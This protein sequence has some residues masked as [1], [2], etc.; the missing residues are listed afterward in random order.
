MLMS[1]VAVQTSAKEVQ[2]VET[3]INDD[4][5]LITQQNLPLF[6]QDKTNLITQNNRYLFTQDNSNLL[7]QDKSLR[8]EFLRL[9]LQKFI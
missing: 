1:A 7:A 2:L 8:Q 4:G 3:D 5:N 6:V 9:T